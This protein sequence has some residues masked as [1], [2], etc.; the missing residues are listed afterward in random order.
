[1]QLVAFYDWGWIR[2]NH[3]SSNLVMETPNS[4][5]LK[6]F[7]FGLNMGKPEQV[8]FNLAWA[9]RIGNNPDANAQGEDADGSR[10][11]GRIWASLRL[12]F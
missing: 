4:Y 6:G 9:R 1:M 7:G 11:L 10:R 8:D 12:F 3:D 2:Q 5:N